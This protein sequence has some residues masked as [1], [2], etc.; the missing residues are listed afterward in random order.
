MGPSGSQ[1]AGSAWPAELPAEVVADLRSD[2]AGETGAVWIYRGVR[3]VTRDA[4]LRDF[5]TRH[6]ATEQAHLQR[7]EAWLPRADRSRLLPIWRLAGW[8]TGA[9]PAL[10]GPKAVYVTIEAVET[11]VDGHY[12]GQI[13]W[14]KGHRELE[15]LRQTLL[16]CQSDEVAHRDEAAA[17]HGGHRVG[18]GWRRW[19]DLVHTGS[20]VAVSVCRRV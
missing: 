1:V 17:L 18:W 9:L 11:F 10:F 19:A 6:G 12:A 14:L 3:S 7:I 15:A 16:D 2:H 5:A 20:R 8:L 13:A 4:A